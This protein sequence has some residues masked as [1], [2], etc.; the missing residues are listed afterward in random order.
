MANAVFVAD[1]DALLMDHPG[2]NAPLFEEKANLFPGQVLMMSDNEIGGSGFDAT[3]KRP[4]TEVPIPH[5]DIVRFDPCQQALDVI[6][7][8]LHVGKR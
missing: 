3:Q 1:T 2:L 8:F 7:G 5:P 6:T 4:R